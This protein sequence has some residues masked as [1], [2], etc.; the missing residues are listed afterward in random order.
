MLSSKTPTACK[1]PLPKFFLTVAHTHNVG[2]VGCIARWSIFPVVTR[3]ASGM[4]SPNYRK[5]SMRPTSGR[6][7]RSTRQTGNLLTG[8]FNVLLSLP[9]RFVLRN[10]RNFWHSISSQVRLQSSTKVGAWKIRGT[11]YFLHV[12]HCLPLSIS[13]VLRSYNSL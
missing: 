5:H 7:A 3:D 9:V 13:T 10:L 8:S 1:A 4:R 6:C 12:R 2:S 11:R